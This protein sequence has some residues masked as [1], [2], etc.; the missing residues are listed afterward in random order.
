MKILHI[1]D[2]H[3]I[4]AIFADILT[5]ANHEFESAIDGKT[6]L[7]M[8]LKNNYDIILLDI[9]LP[10]YTGFDFLVD[11]KIKKPS[12][13]RKV[14]IVSSLQLEEYQTQFL[15]NLGVQSIQKKPISVQHL[16]SKVIPNIS[17]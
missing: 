2:N 5:M 1:E 8:V 3:E 11:L 15:K 4:S 7:G 17:S 9:G 12:E 10:Q 16:M 6:G 13:I 14:I